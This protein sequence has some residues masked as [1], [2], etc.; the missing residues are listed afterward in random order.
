[1]TDDSDYSDVPTGKVAQLRY[2]I[3][4]LWDDLG[5]ADDPKV[6]LFVSVLLA[7]VGVFIYVNFSGWVGFAGVVWAIL[8]LL[9]PIKWVLGL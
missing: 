2:S 5:S 4:N 7:L 3:T 9:G 6:G 1:M 8:N